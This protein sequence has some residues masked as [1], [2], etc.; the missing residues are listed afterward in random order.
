MFQLFISVFLIYCLFKLAERGIRLFGWFVLG[1]IVVIWLDPVSSRE[2]FTTVV[3]W[4][5]QLFL[6][7]RYVI[8]G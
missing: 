8:M 2:F 4:L 5:D 3:H 7:L 1:L 6:R